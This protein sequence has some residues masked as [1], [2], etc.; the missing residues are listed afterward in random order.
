L[1]G[2]ALTG[3]ISE[4]V[5]F[6]LFGLGNNG[7]TV[8]INLLQALYGDYAG[9][10]SFKTFDADTKNDQT[11][12]LAMLKGRRFVSM[13]ES[14]ADRKLNEALVKR[15]TGGDPIQ[16]R[17]LYKE[18]FEYYPQF[19]L[20]LATN[21]KPVI[22]QNDKAIWRRIRLIPFTQNFDGREDRTLEATLKSELPGI[23]NWALEG[24]KLW[25]SEGLEP[26]PQVIKE[27]TEKYKADSDTVGQW[28]EFRTHLNTGSSVKSS[29]AYT[30]YK[31][32][33]V[34]NGYYPVGNRNFKVSL[35]EKKF[36]TQRRG[37]GIYWLGFDLKSLY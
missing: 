20:F 37:D 27:E 16:C 35:E 14:A 9:V 3:D 28:L 36:V 13:S 22:T 7:K 4:Q 26:L 32:W 19:K 34:E 12:D 2:H 31:D 11:N 21:H 24:L 18:F 6:F 10:T 1:V 5:I 29:A 17:F 33:A 15:L 8:L 25:Q 30:N 23:L